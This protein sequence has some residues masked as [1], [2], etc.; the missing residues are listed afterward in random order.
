MAKSTVPATQMKWG[1]TRAEA[2]PLDLG[3]EE[4]EEEDD[5]MDLDPPPTHVLM[6]PPAEQTAQTLRPLRERPPMERLRRDPRTTMEAPLIAYVARLQAPQTAATAVVGSGSSDST[7]G[8]TAIRRLRGAAA[9]ARAGMDPATKKA[10]ST[11]GV[12]AGDSA[13]DG[14]LFGRPL[15]LEVQLRAAS[16]HLRRAALANA[17]AAAASTGLLAPVHRPMA[18]SALLRVGTP[19]LGV[20]GNYKHV[21][22]QPPPEVEKAMFAAYFAK[23]TFAPEV[24]ADMRGHDVLTFPAL[25]AMEREAA[26][27]ADAQREA[28]EDAVGDVPLPSLDVLT[29]DYFQPFRLP[30]AEADLDVTAR[31][32]RSGERCIFFVG[33]SDSR[34]YVGREFLLPSERALTFAELVQLKPRAGYCIDCLLAIWT[35]RS[36]ENAHEH[37]VPARPLNTFTVHV[38]RGEYG[39]HCM[40]DTGHGIDG[41]VPRFSANLREYVRLDRAYAV[42]YGLPE[43]GCYYYAECNMDFREASGPPTAV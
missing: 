35:I 31:H 34:G 39:A 24:E 22:S 18:S 27:A 43:T 6:P 26:K 38:G 7:M 21:L 1:K 9:A 37:V 33:S 15:P 13:Q 32:C 29:R 5:A 3:G 2:T 42:R 8:H 19:G 16:D 20:I 30:I 41:H 17:A 23:D 11:L 14:T 28:F 4:E 10:Q 40:L 25:A 36:E 12:L